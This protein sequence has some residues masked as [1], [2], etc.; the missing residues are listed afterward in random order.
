MGAHFKLLLLSV[1]V[2]LIAVPTLG[3][4]QTGGTASGLIIGKIK[5]EFGRAIVGIDLSVFAYRQGKWL[6]GVFD[7]V[8]G[9]YKIM[10]L[11]AGDWILGVHTR[12]ESGFS[13]SGINLPATLALGGT[14]TQ[15]IIL[16]RLGGIIAGRVSRPDGTPLS[17]A[18]VKVT[19]FLSRSARTLL[20]AE[21]DLNGAFRFLVPAGSY[22]VRAFSGAEDVIDPEPEEVILESGEV[23]TVSLVFDRPDRVIYGQVKI[24][25][26]QFRRRRF[27][28][29]QG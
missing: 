19:D 27:L 26:D 4:A 16:K 22:L 18:L 10:N 20:S 17:R 24:G 28:S 15:D 13:A 23:A 6:E 9:D 11:P 7:K 5:D 14:L 12:P 3:L 21:T 8:T 1:L 25:G 29:S 2:L